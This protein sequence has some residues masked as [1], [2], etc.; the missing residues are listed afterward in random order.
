MPD[1]SLRIYLAGYLANIYRKYTAW[2]GP[3]NK[4]SDGVHSWEIGLGAGPGAEFF[5]N[6]HFGIHLELPWMTFAQI[7]NKELSFLKSYPHIGGG[8]VYYF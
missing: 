1:A 4:T 6:R 7:A 2:E 8:V 5:F 3:K